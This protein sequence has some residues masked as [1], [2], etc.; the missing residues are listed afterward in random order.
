MPNFVPGLKLSKFFYEREVKPILDRAFP[1]LPHSAAL[2]GWGSEVLGFD[3]RVSRDHHWGPRVLL[4]LSETDSPKLRDKISE[5]L[6]AELPY[7][8]L[9]YST[10]YSKP[11]PNGVRHL[12][13]IKSGPVDHMISIYTVRSF[14]KSRLGFDLKRRI[15]IA[16]WLT[17]PQQRLLEF[18]SG[19]VYY[20][21]LGQL[22]KVRERFRYYPQDVWLY[23][24][25][26]QWKRIAQEE[27][28][29]G[30]AGHVGDELGSQ[31]VAARLVREI[32]KLSFLIERRYT[33]Y[34]KWLGTAFSKLKIAKPLTPIL[35]RAL[36]AQTWKT[37]EKWLSEAYSLVAR[38]HN[39]LKITEP[40]STEVTDY[41]SRPYSVI[42]GERFAT[43]IKQAIKDPRVKKIEIDIGSIDQF[44][45]S[46]DV[47]EDLALIKK[48]RAAYQ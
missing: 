13:K 19:E 5:V 22:S 44:T 30:R 3:T 1:R 17:F 42:F 45:D 10:N 47:I 34:S 14:L 41:Y 12:V 33:P 26:A 25:S 28:F 38:Q 37:R 6:S 43:A 8:F 7:E 15:T 24:M 2:I 21:G 36:L 9:G 18:T 40:L 48:L 32:I 23:M 39:A 11:E 16:D 20:D 35:R 29:V 46:T 27:A 4:F 31:I